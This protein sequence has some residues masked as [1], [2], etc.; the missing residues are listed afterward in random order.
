MPYVCV[1]DPPAGEQ[2]ASDGGIH[3]AAMSFGS[4]IRL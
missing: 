4:R 1:G 2:L 3:V